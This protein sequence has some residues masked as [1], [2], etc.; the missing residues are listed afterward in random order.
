MK[1]SF[2]FLIFFIFVN[3][4]LFA[5]QLLIPLNRDVNTLIE[6][7]LNQKNIEFHTSLKPFLKSDLSLVINTDSI[8]GKERNFKSNSKTKQYLWRKLR[9]ENFIIVDSSDFYLTIDPLFNFEAGKNI[10]SDSI[11]FV[12]TR[13][14][15]IQGNIGKNF[16]FSSSFYENQARFVNYITEY[17]NLNKVIPGQGPSKSFK[18]S[19]FDYSSASGYISFTPLKSLN[20][21]IGHGKHFF[22]EGYRSLLLSDN[23]FNYPYIK[24]TFNFW[25]FQYTSMY[26]SFINK[27]SGS[28]VSEFDKKYAT[29]HFL[30]YNITKK[31][32][33]SLFEST[34]WQTIENNKKKNYS[35]EYL[36]PVIFVPAAMYKLDNVNNVMLGLNLR[37]K[38][39]DKFST[40]AQ[41]AVDDVDLSSIK[42]NNGYIK[43]KIAYQIGAKGF[44][45]LRIKNLNI[46]LEYNQSRPY[47]YAHTN[48]AQNYSHYNQSLAHPL[49][50]NFKEAIGILNYRYKDFLVEIKIN[51]AYYG[52][53]TLGSNYGK[54]I[55]Y[56]EI[57]AKNGENS[58]GNSMVQGIKTTLF[59][60]DARIN[61]LVNPSTNL[62]I[63]LGITDRKEYSLVR[64]NHCLFVFFGIRTF[65]T[66]FYYDF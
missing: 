18:T 42:S 48:P 64:D 65:L 9:K 59:I 15:L 58:F 11:A 25:K 19:D 35:I 30:S 1:Y 55:F 46:I 57:T 52:A 62:N 56:S 21:Q 51:Y 2:L 36:N 31:I 43:N 49:G 40:Y 37:Y 22:G 26:T 20:V 12:N 5:Q 34:I 4:Q 29:F 33:F 24:L 28:F 7:R 10:V 54:N 14:F 61:Y 41:L 47:V 50:A 45:I 63:F 23:A 17:V 38:L 44:D 3:S 16:S 39:F 27:V 6:E 66:N 60:K 13:G 32:N 53:D 8:T